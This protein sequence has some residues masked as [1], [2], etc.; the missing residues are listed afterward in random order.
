MGTRLVHTAAEAMRSRVVWLSSAM[1]KLVTHIVPT[2]VREGPVKIVRMTVHR[3]GRN[4][5]T[6]LPVSLP[7]VT[8]IA[9]HVWNGVQVLLVV[10][11]EF[12][13]ELDPALT[14]GG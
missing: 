14:V 12:A 7:V 9:T 1:W 6:V 2:D 5:A 3:M 10:R 4:N 8:T 11:R 13:R